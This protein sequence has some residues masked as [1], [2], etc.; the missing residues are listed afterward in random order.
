MEGFI[1]SGPDLQIRGSNICSYLI[2]HV[3]QIVLILISW[4]HYSKIKTCKCRI[5]SNSVK[6]HYSWIKC[7]NL[8]SAV[9]VHFN[10]SYRP[11]G[12]NV[13]CC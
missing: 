8:K 6:F 12:R 9:K 10:C 5:K 13:L 11:C 1:A 3:G 4:L 2:L 7:Q